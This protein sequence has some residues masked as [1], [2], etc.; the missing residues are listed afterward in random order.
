MLPILFGL[1]AAMVFGLVGYFTYGL[2]GIINHTWF[3][4]VF[5]LLIVVGAAISLLDEV[6]RCLPCRL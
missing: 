4:Q 3:N 6:N 1:I 2:D 5:W